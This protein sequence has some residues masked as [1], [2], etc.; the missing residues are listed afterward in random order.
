MA[1]TLQSNC[2]GLSRMLSSS[3]GTSAVLEQARKT[4]PL[5][6]RRPGNSRT[7]PSR[8]RSAS[9]LQ[10]GWPMVWRLYVPYS[11]YSFPFQPYLQAPHAI[12]RNFLFPASTEMEN[13]NGKTASCPLSG[14][15]LNLSKSCTRACIILRSFES[16]SPCIYSCKELSMIVSYSVIGLL[17]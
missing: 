5:R 7:L 9:S 13:R 1:K 15:G 12:R 17:G 6:T 3:R 4:S 11:P 14:A 16:P 10:K 8:P 2:D